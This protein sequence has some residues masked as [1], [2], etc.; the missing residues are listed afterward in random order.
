MAVQD[1]L[2]GPGRLYIAP[3]TTANPDETTV[4]YGAAWGGS[5]VD[6]GDFVEGSGITLGLDEDVVKVYGEQSTGVKKQSRVRREM[7]VTCTLQEH[8]VVNMAYVLDGTATTT[9]AG[10][11]Q[12]GYSDIPFGVQ[13]DVNT[14]KFGIEALRQDTADNNQPVRW[15]LHKGSIRLAGDIPYAKQNVTGVPIEITI[16]EDDTQSAGE[17]LGILQIVTA[18][19]TS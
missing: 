9:A 15:F 2:I 7:T 10:A 19:A 11:S 8:S 3:T 6:L 12:K 14:Y 4:A 1:V 18:A 16:L 17:E 13:A 5:W